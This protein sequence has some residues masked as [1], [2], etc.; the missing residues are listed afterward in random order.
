[1]KPWFSIKN[2][3]GIAKIYLYGDIS[4]YD[5]NI[6]DFVTKFSQIQA[7]EI[8]VHINSLGGDVFTGIAIYSTLIQSD[9][10]IMTF[11]DGVAASIASVIALGG[12]KV[13]MV[14][15]GSFMIHKISGLSYGNAKDH[16][17]T[18]ELLEQLEAQIIDIYNQKTGISSEE[19]KNMLDQETWLNAEQAMEKG[20]VDEIV[21]A[22]KITAPDQPE[23]LKLKHPERLTEFF[24]SIQKP[25]KKEKN[26]EEILKL[27]GISNEADAP[28][29]IKSLIAGVAENEAL[30]TKLAAFE[31]KEITGL[32][33]DAV[34]SGKITEAQRD[35]AFN[36]AVNHREQFD[37]FLKT[38]VK[39]VEKY[40][41][42]EAEDLVNN[43]ITE[44]KLFP[45][46]KDWAVNL[47]CENKSSFDNF[48]S[49]AKPFNLDTLQNLGD[50]DNTGEPAVEVRN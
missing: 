11:I 49:T 32:V 2:E 26:M 7:P 39:T 47:A 4:T 24:N 13:F 16:Q 42:T 46:Q 35:W 9:K 36:L 6:Q 50:P 18:A 31:Q 3:A 30:K 8:H 41:Q 38:S 14:R 40:S 5:E 37:A 20:F 25:S 48:I 29:K 28:I 27:L 15:N 19:L 33:N 34:T 10:K 23:N 43:A 12:E 17:K 22:M 1:M 45:A 44:K 21:A